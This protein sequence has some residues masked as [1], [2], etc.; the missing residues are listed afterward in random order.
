MTGPLISRILT[1][2]TI[3]VLASLTGHLL[4]LSNISQVSSHTQR[5]S[6]RRGFAFLHKNLLVP[7]EPLEDDPSSYRTRM[8][9]RWK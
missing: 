3:C 2:D 4:L 7:R 9:K 1:I 6:V 8:K 5:G